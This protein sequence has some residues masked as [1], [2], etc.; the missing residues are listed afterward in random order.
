ME[1]DR[2]SKYVAKLKYVKDKNGSMAGER[3]G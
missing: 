2:K 3:D 1:S